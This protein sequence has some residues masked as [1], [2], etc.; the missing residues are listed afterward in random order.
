[1]T[2]TVDFESPSRTV[3]LP[4]QRNE[5]ELA[6]AITCHKFQGSEARIVVIPIHRAFGPRVCQRN[7]L[8][9]GISRAKEV[10]VLVGQRDEITRIIG[11]DRQQR[12][13][14]RL[15]ELLQ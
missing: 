13:F 11:R 15:A 14:T 8:Y 5:L 9:T 2:D 10:C 4:L 7:W 3:S 1:M 12:R 6:Y